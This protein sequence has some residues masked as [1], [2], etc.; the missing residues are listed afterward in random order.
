MKK[1]HI[2]FSRIILYFILICQ[3]IITIYPLLWMVISSLKDN[4]SFFADPWSL[5]K[6][7]QFSNYVT[8]WNEGIQDY[9][10]NSVLITVATLA[11]V[12]I[13]SCAFSFMVSRFPF[14]GS[15]ILVSMFFA[16]M[17]I[18]VHCTLVPLYT[19]M[20][21]L[22]WLDSLPSLLF[23]Y[24]ASSL[25]LAIFLTFGH[26]Q[27]IPKEL[28]EAAWMDGCGII[29]LFFSIF[30]PLAKPVLSTIAILTA[31]SI[32][33]EFIFANIIIS[34]PLK[35]T[36]PVG[37]LSLKGTYNTNYAALSAALTISAVPIILIYILMSNKI[38]SGMVAGAVKS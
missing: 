34:D 17:M 1:K 21:N 20:N 38:Q 29:R 23:P 35:K 19:M 32:W 31:I 26:Y 30:F 12:I 27:Q 8:A 2:S 3:A 24:V 11:I 10:I 4:I 28:E 15:G 25:P 33:N 6:N 16:G 22:G 9:M 14:K 13:I 37:L 36:L 18:P 7:P 5:P